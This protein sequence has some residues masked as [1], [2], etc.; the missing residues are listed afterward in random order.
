MRDNLCLAGRLGKNEYYFPVGSAALL[1]PYEPFVVHLAGANKST[2]GYIGPRT[3]QVEHRP[4]V[5]DRFCGFTIVSVQ[6]MPKRHFDRSGQVEKRFGLCNWMQKFALEIFCRRRRNGLS[7][8]R[9]G[10]CDKSH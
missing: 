10:K 5:G 9:D 2:P 3:R 6:L 7:Q 8:R 1:E 4:T